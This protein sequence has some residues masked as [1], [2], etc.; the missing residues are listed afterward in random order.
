VDFAKLERGEIVAALGGLLLAI[1]VFVPWY[2]T[3]SVNGLLADVQGPSSA[4]GWEAHPIL[5]W[6]MLAAAA[7]PWILA[8][9]VLRE[10]QLSWPRGQVTM[11]V[12]IAAIGLV[13]FNGLIDR[14]GEPPNSIGLR[15]GWL[16]A[17]VGC[18]LMLAG[19]LVR[20][21]EVEVARKP[22]GVI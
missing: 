4:T 8:W 21:S 22:P 20:Q 12:A 2:G 7:A 16:I 18:G 9:I 10:H 1:A 13:L 17:L 15:I 5:R 14:P 11:V 19:S 6:L 3:D